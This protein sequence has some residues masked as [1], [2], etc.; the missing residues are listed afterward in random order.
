[1]AVWYEVEKTKKSIDEFLDCNWG[2]MICTLIHRKIMMQT[3]YMA[4]R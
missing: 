1:M 4:V 2:F 3:G